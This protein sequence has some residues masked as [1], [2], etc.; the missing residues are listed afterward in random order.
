MHKNSLKFTK[1]NGNPQ[2]LNT[3][4]NQSPQN[5]TAT[6]LVMEIWEKFRWLQLTPSCTN[7]G[8]HRKKEE[9]SPCQSHRR[10]KS[11]KSWVEHSWHRPPSEFCLSY[12]HN[13]GC[14]HNILG[15]FD[16]SGCLDFGVPLNFCVLLW[17]SWHRPL[18]CCC[19][20]L[21]MAHEINCQNWTLL[22]LLSVICQAPDGAD[23]HMWQTCCRICMG[24]NF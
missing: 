13:P 23:I 6:S 16:F 24:L 10:R 4:W 12:F 17:H 1:F 14:S 3:H 21:A 9:Q 11:R 22:E 7:Q 2:N 15:G 5:V 20:L 19:F 8:C 18:C